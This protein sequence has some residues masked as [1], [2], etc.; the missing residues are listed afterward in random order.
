MSNLRRV[1]RGDLKGFLEARLRL[2]SPL[3]WRGAGGGASWGR[4]L[5]VVLLVVVLAATACASP[6]ATRTRSGGPGGDIGNHDAVPDIHGTTNPYY[7]TPRYN[8]GIAQ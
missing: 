8:K 3:R 2:P 4:I 7:E 5:S 1:T 6:E